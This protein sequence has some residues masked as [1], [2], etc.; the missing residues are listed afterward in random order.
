MPEQKNHMREL[1]KK[2][3]WTYLGDYPDQPIYQEGFIVQFMNRRPEPDEADIEGKSG[4]DAGA[5]DAGEK[6]SE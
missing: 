2:Y 5:E 1:A 3:G 6:R 4:P